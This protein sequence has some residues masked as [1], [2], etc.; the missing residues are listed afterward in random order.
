MILEVE[1][2]YA[3]VVAMKITSTQPRLPWDFRL[4]DWADIPLDHAST[5]Q[6]S[7]VMR[8]RL[9]NMKHYAGRISDADWEKALHRFALYCE[10]KNRP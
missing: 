5:I 1:Q 2:E 6:P 9:S 4:Q 7:R 10:E 8:I 3:T